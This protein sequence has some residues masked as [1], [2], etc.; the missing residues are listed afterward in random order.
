MGATVKRNT[1]VRTENEVNVVLKGVKCLEYKMDGTGK[2][3]VLVGAIEQTEVTFHMM[4]TESKL[5]PL[6]V[7][8][9]GHTCRGDKRCF[10]QLTFNSPR[11]Q[12][13]VPET[14]RH[15]NGAVHFELGVSPTQRNSC[16]APVSSTKGPCW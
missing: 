3:E 4:T 1:T 5:V 13:S 9:S 6:L 15:E 7:S 8:I 12:A 14:R 16:F 10:G 2:G 11:R